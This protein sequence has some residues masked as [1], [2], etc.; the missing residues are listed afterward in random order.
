MS[1]TLTLNTALSGLNI[2]Q[3]ALSVLSQNIANANTP[4]YSRQILDLS[5]EYVNGQGAGV[6]IEGVN[7]KVDT[8]L[9]K[10]LIEQQSLSGK[11]GV[12]ND[13]SSRIQLRLGQ[14]GSSNN[15]SA[16]ING[17]FNALETLAIQPSDASS[18]A[19]AVRTGV[20]LADDFNVLGTELQNLRFE[21]DQDINQSVAAVNKALNELFEVNVKI[22]A[23][24][25]AGRSTV[26]L[27]DR[28]DELINDI[29]QYINVQSVRRETGQ[30]HIFTSNGIALMDESLHQLRYNQAAS[31][32]SFVNDV[33][34]GA[35]DVV[36]L[37]QTGREFGSPAV[38]VTGGSSSQA[39]SILQTGKLAA[40][41]QLRDRDLPNIL[42]QLDLLAATV[43]DQVNAIHNTGSGYPGS[44][45]YVGTRAVNATEYNEWSGS[46][47]I[48][49][50]NEQGKPVG[51]YYPDQAAMPPLTIDFSKLN[52]GGND[53]Q[54]TVQGII[55]TI[56]QY[57]LPRNKTTVGGISNVQ[58]VSMTDTLPNAANQLSFDLDLQ[59]LGTA[60]ADFFLTGVT[61]R[62][63]NNAVM[64]PAATSTQPSFSIS[65]YDT[66]LGSEVITINTGGTLPNVAVGDMIY[67]SNP[68]G[69]IGGISALQMTGYFE[70]TNING[71]SFD[72][73]APAEAT[74]TGTHIP[75]GTPSA[76]SAYASLEPGDIMR[77]KSN[78]FI[79]ADLSANP[80]SVFYTISLDVGVPRAQGGGVDMATVTYRIQNN[81]VSM[82]NDYYGA[83]SV[84]GNADLINP[85]TSSPLVRAKL[86]DANGNELPSFQ[87]KYTGNV[88]GYLV[89]ETLSSGMVVAIDSGDSLEQGRSSDVPPLAGTLRGF[90]HY[91]ELNNFFSSTNPSGSAVT[92][93]AQTLKVEQ[94]LR[95]VPSRISLGTLTQSTTVSYA[96]ERNIGDNSVIQRLSGLNNTSFLYASTGGLGQ[97]SR[98]F[99][100][101]S[102]Q[103]IADVSTNANNHKINAENAQG[104]LE[105]FQIQIGAVSGV[106]LDQELANTVIYQNAYAATARIITVV[107]QLFD[108]LLQ[109]FG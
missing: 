34:L 105:G 8:Y 39:S 76:L 46:M 30:M 82:I 107:N 65:S 90:S 12:L 79:T 55:D 101:Y 70:I 53:G 27:Q 17:F 52:T 16:N 102:G 73:K 108:T 64:T 2:N 57:F 72:I 60:G 63:S 36:A 3:Q 10:A 56:N 54:P 18:Q 28:Q 11:H 15:L 21:A 13:Y 1:L 80:T 85:G 86:V 68:G 98:T 19:A 7:R 69:S 45:S 41:V 48:A 83:S 106:N 43:R 49:V 23:D 93:T 4:G 99:A 42:S 22:T 20:S 103:I 75:V 32:Q 96:L 84:S 89:I 66:T 61:I 50:L 25:L 31:V 91:F 71:S 88:D 94:R 97:T 95:D 78:G 5:A 92:N 109:S 104:L 38:L 67:L 77:T 59:N 40:L 24:T 74:S 58:L 37:D 14:P 44:S 26:P 33:S 9:N 100:G 87:G 62:D 6:S 35:I 51:S 81:T 47:Q 29:A